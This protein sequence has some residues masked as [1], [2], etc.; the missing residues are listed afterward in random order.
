MVSLSTRFSSNPRPSGAYRPP[1]LAHAF[2]KTNPRGAPWRTKMRHFVAP[3][4]ATTVPCKTKPSL[5]RRDVAAIRQ[6]EPTA[7][8]FDAHRQIPIIRPMERRRIQQL[9][10]SLVNRIAAGEVIERPAAVVKEL[11][12]NAMDA[13]AT[14]I[15]VEV[16]DGGR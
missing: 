10:P 9:S 16:E 7:S 3:C 5:P 2:G 8:V 6:N 1:R 4:C 14:S 15:L 13:G 12:E 11:V